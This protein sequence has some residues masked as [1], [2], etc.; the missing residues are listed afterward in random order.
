MCA[1]NGTGSTMQ[2]LLRAKSSMTET[3]DSI[4]H[5]SVRAQNFDTTRE[6]LEY[7]PEPVELKRLSIPFT[8][9]LCVFVYLMC[10]VKP[11]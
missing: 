5:A 11:L 8:G 2:K 3:N 4:L 1:R 6:I 10:I 9:S 7:I